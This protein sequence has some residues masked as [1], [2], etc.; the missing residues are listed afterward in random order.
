MAFYS[1]ARIWADSITIHLPPAFFFLSGIS[2]SPL[3]PLFRP[4]PIFSGSVNW[5]DIVTVNIHDWHACS[6][7][8]HGLSVFHLSCRT[9]LW[10]TPSQPIQQRSLR[11]KET[12]LYYQTQFQV[13]GIVPRLVKGHFLMLRQQSGTLSFMKSGHLTPSHPLN[14]HL[15]LIFLSCPTDCVC[16]GGGGGGMESKGQREREN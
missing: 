9:G 15:K 12:E 8:A 10:L 4:G 5:D 3:I 16:G 7:V 13:H 11:R 14:H 2:S 6:L 1:H